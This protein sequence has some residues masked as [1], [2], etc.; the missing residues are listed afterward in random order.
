MGAAVTQLDGLEP[1]WLLGLQPRL[2]LVHPFLLFAPVPCPHSS[3]TLV[4]FW[5]CYSFC[6]LVLHRWLVL[7]C[8]DRSGQNSFLPSY[9]VAANTAPFS[10]HPR[11]CFGVL[12]PHSSRSHSSLALCSKPHTCSFCFNSKVPIFLLLFSL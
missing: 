2:R 8:A 4:Q 9:S 11:P 6:Y 1:P 5:V 7:G 3:T 10:P 12:H